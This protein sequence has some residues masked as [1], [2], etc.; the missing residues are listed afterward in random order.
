VIRRALDIACS[1]VGV[2]LLAPL[3]LIVAL[4]VSLESSGPPFYGGRRVGLH[5]REFRMWKFRTM[6]ADADRIGPGITGKGDA[7]ITRVGAFLRRTKIDELP[8]FFNLL[9]G[10]LTLVGPRAEVPAIVARYS[11]AQRS[12]LDVKPGIVGP[13]QL[14]Y[15]TDQQDVI[16]EGV[17]ADDY[18]VEH[19]LGPKLAIDMEYERRRTAWS[20]VRMVLATVV[21]MLRGLVGKH[22]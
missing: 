22:A 8:Q 13:G 15:T 17:A 10:E 11:D 9:T 16:P 18:Y 2:L 21:V 14:Y 7:R 6:V 19:L 1:L 20:D 12:I 4:V 5:G 3:F